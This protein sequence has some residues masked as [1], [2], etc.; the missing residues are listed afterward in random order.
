[1]ARILNDKQWH[2][3]ILYPVCRVR[4]PKGGGSGTVLYSAPVPGETDIHETYILTNHH[5]IEACIKI[6]KLWDSVVKRKIDKEQLE[7]ASVEIFTYMNLSRRDS[8]ATYEAE[9]MAY[10]EQHDLAVLKLSTPRKVDYVA[11]LYPK[12]EEKKLYINTKVWAVGC[13]LLHDPLPHSGT[14]SSVTERIDNVAYWMSSAPII[15]GNSGG[16]VFLDDGRFIGVPSRVV[17]VPMGFSQSVVSFM[18]YFIPVDRIYKFL[19]E[20]DLQFIYDS[21]ET[22]TACFKRREDKQKMAMEALI[23]KGDES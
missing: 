15:F 4:S 5:V 11:E 17:V 6:E 7:R 16:A 3:K 1:M 22:S 21:S 14:I 23:S 9:I 20:Q 18:G 10:N 12:D 19:I 8:G 13:S 2:E